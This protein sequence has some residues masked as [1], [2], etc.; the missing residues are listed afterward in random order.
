[1]QFPRGS[2]LMHDGHMAEIWGKDYDILVWIESKCPRAFSY[3]ISALNRVRSK[4]TPCRGL[5]I[6]EYCVISLYHHG[7]HCK[8]LTW[9]DWCGILYEVQTWTNFNNVKLA[10]KILVGPH[11]PPPSDIT[12]VAILRELPCLIIFMLACPPYVVYTSRKVDEASVAPLALWNHSIDGF[13]HWKLEHVNSC[14]PR[15]TNSKLMKFKLR[16][17]FDIGFGIHDYLLPNVMF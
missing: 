10:M 6:Q 2:Q 17:V 14:K 12:C 8:A 3:Y 7:L 13:E 1:M 16:M 15:P 9:N 5:W 11:S 4:E